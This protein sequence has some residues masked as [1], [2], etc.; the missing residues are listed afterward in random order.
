M[1]Y[2]RFEDYKSPEAS[3][4][5]T[6]IRSYILIIVIISSFFVFWLSRSKKQVCI[7]FV[8]NFF[9]FKDTIILIKKKYFQVCWETAIGQDIYRFIIINFIL[10]DLFGAIFFLIRFLIYKFI[11]KSI[12]LPEFSISR[13][14][15]TLV[16]NQSFLWI[17]LF[18]SPFLAT[19]MIGKMIVTFYLKVTT[20]L[21]AYRDVVHY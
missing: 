21:S 18:F 3:I 16:F 17:G 19:L 9:Y 15:L 2:Y 11:S 7:Q 20:T 4:R 6:L 1:V 10:V 12:G 14:S 13:S 8:Y 5:V